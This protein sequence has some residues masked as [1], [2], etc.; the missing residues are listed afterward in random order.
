MD[1]ID[2]LR[3][4]PSGT[5]KKI[6]FATSAVV[7]LAIF[8]VWASVLHFGIDSKPTEVTAAVANIS[9]ADV[10]PFV[11]FWSVISTGWGGLVDN[12]NQIKTGVDKAKDLVGA[13]NEATSTGSADV[14]NMQS[15]SDVFT[16]S[17]AST[18]ADKITQ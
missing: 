12:I 9:D 3:Q 10:N 7:T 6:A 11:G 17:G 8:G 14:A 1:F 5:K 15:P 2:N 18:S 13:L 16:L 4:K